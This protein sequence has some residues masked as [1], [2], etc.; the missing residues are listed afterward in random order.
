MN[1]NERAEVVVDE[2]A[3][4]MLCSGIGAKGDCEIK[5]KRSETPSRW[6]K[7]LSREV[8]SMGTTGWGFVEESSMARKE[9][10]EWVIGEDSEPARQGA[11]WNGN[12]VR[13]WPS[14]MWSSDD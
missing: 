9:K 7:K 1:R 13:W 10:Q 12:S 5:E 2:M 11:S 6:R 3:P 14:L 4:S 8:C